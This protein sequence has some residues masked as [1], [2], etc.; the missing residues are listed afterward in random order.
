MYSF[1][2]EERNNK[3][4]LASLSHINIKNARDDNAKMR[5][6]YK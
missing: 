6:R 4:E 1:L 2:Y 3:T 5:K